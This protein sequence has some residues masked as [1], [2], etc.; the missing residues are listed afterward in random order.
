MQELQIL[1]GYFFVATVGM[2]PL[3]AIGKRIMCRLWFT[4]L[5]DLVLAR[6]QLLWFP[7]V[8]VS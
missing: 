1:R 6:D 7:L 2:H 4:T 5:W 3:L 8:V